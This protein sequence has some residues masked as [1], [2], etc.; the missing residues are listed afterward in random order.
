MQPA[1]AAVPSAGS[2]P[3]SDGRR[4]LAIMRWGLVPYWSKDAK[5]S[6]KTINAQAETVATGGSYRE[7]FKRRLH[8]ID[9]CG[10]SLR[11]R[12]RGGRPIAIRG[13]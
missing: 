11:R 7:P 2:S 8:F 13:T 12:W 1:P 6:Y 10:H 4:E 5:P 9:R 3:L